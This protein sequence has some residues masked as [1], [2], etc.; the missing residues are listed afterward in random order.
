MTLNVVDFW[1]RIAPDRRYCVICVPLPT[2]RQEE[3]PD[4]L[5]G[6]FRHEEFRTIAK[7]LGKVVRLAKSEIAVY[8]ISQRSPVKI[9]WGEIQL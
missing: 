6:F 7:R 9:S 8:S 2:E 5:L 4:L 1:R 3:L